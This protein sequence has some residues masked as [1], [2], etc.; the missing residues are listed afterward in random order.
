MKVYSSKVRFFGTF[1][2]VH[3][4]IT[5][6][7]M[8]GL[9]KAYSVDDSWPQILIQT[10]L[11]GYVLFVAANMIGDGAELLLLVPA[12]AALVGSIVIPI[13]GAVPDGMMVL[14][15]GLG[16]D[17]QQQLKVGIGA[18]A[19]STIMLLTLPWV[20][21]VFAGRVSIRD[22]KPQYKRPKNA[23]D[24]WQ[25]LSDED[26]SPFSSLKTSGVGI[27]PAIQTNAKIMLLTA[28]SYL[29]IQLP[30]FWVD[31][32]S[33]APQTGLKDQM[34]FEKVPAWIGLFVC[35]GLFFYYLYL[36]VKAA[37]SD[38]SP[39]QA[40]AVQ[41]MVEGIKAGKVTL[42]GVMADF[43][44]GAQAIQ[45][46]DF[47]QS[48][49][50]SSP[51]AKAHVTYMCQVLEPFFTL[52]DANFD[53]KLSKEEFKLV[54]KDM[55]ER[56]DEGWV[57]E[58]FRKIDTDNSGYLD[59]KEFVTCVANFSVDT[60]RP[61]ETNMKSLMTGYWKT[62]KMD[63]EAQ[64][65]DDEEGAEEEE[66]PE[67]LADLDPAEQQKR[68]KVRAFQG[69]FLGTFLVLMFSDPM[70]DM[71]GL[72]GDKSG[73][74]KFYVSFVLAPLASNASEL[75]AAMKLASKKTMGSMVNSLSSLE[76]AGIMN[77]TFCLGIFLFL[78]VYKDAITP[79]GLVW[80]F[81]AETLSILI[82]E[83]MVA[84]IVLLKPT[85]TCFDAILV[86]M[87]Y[88]LALLIVMFL[89]NVVGLD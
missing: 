33:W 48:L 70:C 18:L 63:T 35:I 44:A 23:P 77:N 62:T 14:C 86:F 41:T 82:I 83:V 75:V 16:P 47:Q 12:Y 39:Q 3:T 20:L 19:G 5:I 11:Y 52:Y 61:T 24:G 71:L 72:I 32:P 30:A 4:N 50:G 59:F 42:R 65:D 56:V 81:S 79:A 1:S 34:S 54:M 46:T 53:Q 36:M 38:D 80:Q 25:K 2:C 69:M 13:L 21:A 28:V 66:L 37:N 74:P 60:S 85:Q 51:E 58:Q 40:K 29:I 22:G 43:Q 89:E 9:F 67:D 78:I 55:G 87:C 31:K 73:V 64:T 84:G 15:S 45:K 26:S 68:I 57:D 6:A 76:G 49:Y 8:E 17:A 7:A 10:G 27:G 88:P